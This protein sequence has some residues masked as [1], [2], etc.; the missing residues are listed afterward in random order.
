MALQFSSSELAKKF[1][2]PKPTRCSGDFSRIMNF[3]E[4]VTVWKSTEPAKGSFFLILHP[5]GMSGGAFAVFKII[6]ADGTT[7]SRTVNRGTV[8]VL[9]VDNAVETTVQVQNGPPDQ[10][11]LVEFMYCDLDL[12]KESEDNCCPPPLVCDQFSGFIFHWEAQPFLT[13]ET[14]FP[15]KGTLAFKFLASFDPAAHPSAT[16]K[17]ERFKKPD[18]VRNIPLNV[19]NTNRCEIPFVLAVDDIRKVTVTASEIDPSNSSLSF[20]LCHQEESA[21]SY[22][23][24]PLKCEAGLIFFHPELPSQDI[25]IWESLIPVKGTFSITNGYD[26]TLTLNIA[27][28]NKKTFERI[29]GSGETFTITAKEV[30]TIT[31]RLNPLPTQSGSFILRYCIQD[32]PLQKTCKAS[33]CPTPLPCNLLIDSGINTLGEK[34]PLWISKIPTDGELFFEINGQPQYR[35]KITI[36]RFGKPD[37]V[38]TIEGEKIFVIRTT[39]WEGVFA[40]LINGDPSDY[41]IRIVF[42][43]QEQVCQNAKTVCCPEPVKC[44]FDDSSYC[45]PYFGQKLTNA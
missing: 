45:P 18:I 38:R 42:C 1:C 17:V 30:K 9:T 19:S 12:I 20:I 28:D 36:K 10:T 34:I 41:S 2:P 37:I 11:A 26:G 24:D 23:D 35:T 15:V 3:N 7:I 44:E 8:H 14:F 21:A 5:Q 4:T 32:M 31:I 22:C 13:W 39:D 6:Q 27:F 33:C 40:E 29:I 25:K 43:I 16:I